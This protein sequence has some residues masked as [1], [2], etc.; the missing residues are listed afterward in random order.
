MQQQSIT[1]LTNQHLQELSKDSKNI[2]YVEQQTN[3]NPFFSY[4]LNANEMKYFVK[5]TR[6]ICEKHKQ[7]YK[8][9][10]TQQFQKQLIS[11]R[12]EYKKFASTYKDIFNK[13]TQVDLSESDLNNVYY[14]IYISYLLETKQ[15]NQTQA[16]EL[17][18]KYLT[19]HCSNNKE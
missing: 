8:N 6:V 19:L 13:I 5:Q 4:H 15:I 18:K 17:I 7:Q 9:L 11:Q 16:Q 2:V 3:I 14:M 12:E 1:T 10:T